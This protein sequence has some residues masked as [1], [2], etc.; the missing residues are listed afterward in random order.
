VVI[1]EVTLVSL[2]RSSFKFKDFG[3]VIPYSLVDGWYYVGG[4]I[5]RIEV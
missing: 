1:E 5:F 4:T 2:S 3:D